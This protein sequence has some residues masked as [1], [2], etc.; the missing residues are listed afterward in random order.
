MN[1]KQNH[2]RSWNYYIAAI[3]KSFLHKSYKIHNYFFCDSAVEFFHV[4]TNLK[5]FNLVLLIKIENIQLSLATNISFVHQ[6][7]QQPIYNLCELWFF[8]ME[9]QF[10]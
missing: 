2:H 9:L 8:R 4:R 7:E 3:F 5:V 10:R 1:F 6:E